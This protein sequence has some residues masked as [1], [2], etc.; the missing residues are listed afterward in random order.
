MRRIYIGSVPVLGDDDAPE[1][2]GGRGSVGSSE[3][4][5]SHNSQ[6]RK[7]RLDRISSQSFSDMDYNPGL[8]T[9]VE[10]PVIPVRRQSIMAG[11]LRI[12]PKNVFPNNEVTSSRVKI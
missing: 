8:T 7:S 11:D 5:P 3:A 2:M 10:N 6:R 4:P 9:K 12:P 1:D